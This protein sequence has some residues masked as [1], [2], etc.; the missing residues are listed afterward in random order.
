MNEAFRTLIT[1]EEYLRRCD[2]KTGGLFGVSC[3]LGAIVSG[4][5][6]TA[7]GSLDRF[8]RYL[9]LAFQIFDD[10]LDFSGDAG[11]TGKI[12]GTD[13]RDGTVTL[14]LIF[15]M[16]AAPGLA[17]LVGKQAKS[18]AEVDEV[19]SQVRGGDALE[20]ARTAAL[21]YIAEARELLTTIDPAVEHELLKQLAGR[22]IDRYS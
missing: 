18:D 12:P 7:V 4:L 6:D 9:G 21:G 3:A 10:I 11:S 5:S 15:A 13:V 16:E 19:V 17:D 20:R 22:V 8:G 14:P 2:L 1:P